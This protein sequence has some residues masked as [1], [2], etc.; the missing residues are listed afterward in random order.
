MVART[1]DCFEQ[2]VGANVVIS[3]PGQVPE[4]LARFERIADVPDAQGPMSGLLAV[5]RWAPHASWLIAPCDLPELSEAALE[6]LLS[7]RAPGTWATLPSLDSS[8]HIE[9]LL[10][11]YDFRSRPLL[12]HLAAQDNFRLRDIASHPKV[13]IL[14]VPPQL[15]PAWK[16]ANSPRD[17]KNHSDPS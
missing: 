6:W 3:G 9:P 8:S 16:N 17:L 4:S 14:P 15:Q 1:I 11:H 7:T 2:I 13:H 12:E 10:A 5:M